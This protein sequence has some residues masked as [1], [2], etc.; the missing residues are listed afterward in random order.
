[1]KQDFLFYIRDYSSD[2][3]YTDTQVYPVY[4]DITKKFAHDSG[5][6]FFRTTLEG[7]IKLEGDDFDLMKNKS[8]NHDLNFIIT[9]LNKTTNLYESYY[10]GTLNKVDCEFDYDKKICTLGFDTNDAYE[11]ILDN[12]ENTYDLI[13]L[14]C[15]TSKMD[16]KIRP[17]LQFYE[18]G[19]SSITNCC[20]GSYWQSD[21]QDSVGADDDGINIMNGTNSDTNDVKYHFN[22]LYYLP[23]LTIEKNDSTLTDCS[24]VFAVDSTGTWYAGGSSSIDV[25]YTMY[26]KNQKYF[27]QFQF[28]G[29]TGDLFIGIFDKDLIFWDWTKTYANQSSD[30]KS[31]LLYYKTWTNVLPSS[32]PFLEH[33][34][35][36]D[37][38][39]TLVNPS[40]SADTIILT[41]FLAHHIY[42]R[43]IYKTDSDPDNVNS[44]DLD[45]YDRFVSNKSEN[46]Y[47]QYRYISSDPKLWQ[48]VAAAT[49]NQS[50]GCNDFDDYY[51]PEYLYTEFSTAER[52]IPLCEDDWGNASM[53][54]NYTQTF[55]TMGESYNYKYT[56]KDAFYISDVINAF[57]TRLGCTTI[58]HAATTD[59]SKFFYGSTD[60]LGLTKFY[61]FITQKSNIL[62]GQYD[63]AASVAKLTFKSFLDMLASCFH[64]YWAIDNNKF[65]LEHAYYFENGGSYSADIRTTQVDLTTLIHSYNNKKY[66]Y[67]QNI[68]KYDSSE[69]YHR[70]EFSWSDKS[71][72]PFSDIYMNI[73]S[74]YVDKSLVQNITVSDFCVDVDYMLSS[75][76][77]FSEDGFALLLPVKNT[78]GTFEL[79]IGTLQ[80][81]DNNN[82]VSYKA[83][84][85]NYLATWTNLINYYLYDL[86]G[87]S[88]QFTNSDESITLSETIV[89]KGIKKFMTQE[90]RFKYDS[91]P[92]LI[93]YIKTELGNGQIDSMSINIDTRV[94]IATLVFTPS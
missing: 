45:Y 21:V 72:G 34:S 15:A 91:D 48:T 33:T 56:L 23:E 16:L 18:L 51:T 61:L 75:P 41:N 90:V 70:Y 62:K 1:M 25:Y 66:S 9:R 2:T 77:S 14:H 71:S 44:F 63:Q 82:N 50:Y 54:F 36:F 19:S 40:N 87:D 17:M 39:I 52:L 64:V 84:I 7:T 58:T 94:V 68:V 13:K 69:L 67:F 78:D 86:S 27:I 80:L 11:K 74:K 93:N 5:Q 35:M 85:Q 12:Y 79:P 6:K 46:N 73:L 47:N 92:D 49:L 38:D 28:L 24:G 3:V 89:V 8:I 30:V 60:V 43:L 65:I 26:S 53:W 83:Y 20:G 55:E 22:N 29:T 88:V 59:Y 10:N 4:K 76:S 31:H 42:G 32:H 81:Y 57:L 37:N